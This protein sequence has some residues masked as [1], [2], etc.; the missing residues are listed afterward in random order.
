MKKKVLAI[1]I[2]LTLILNSSVIVFAAPFDLTYSAD[3]TKNYTF[4]QF[5]DSPSV[6]DFVASNLA[7]YE[8]EGL[9]GIKYSAQEINNRTMLGMDFVQAVASIKAA[10]AVTTAEGSLSQ[11]DVDIAQALI[12]GLPDGADKTALQDRLNIVIASMPVVPP[13]PLVT[14]NDV[15]NTVT[16]M[17][18]GMEYNLDNA[19]Y[20][21]YV[22]GIFNALDF[23]GNHTLLV[24]VAAVG[25]NPPS[26]DTTLTFTTNPGPPVTNDDVA[27][28]VF[29]MTTEMEY[30]YDGAAYVL[31]DEFGFNF[32]S[33]NFHGEHILLV[34]Y[35]ANP[36]GPVT[37]LI[38]TLRPGPAVINDDATNTVTGMSTAMEYNLDGAGYVTY[39][40]TTFNALDFN[41]NHILLVRYKA[42]PFLGHPASLATTLTFTTN[43][44]PQVTNDDI[45]NTVTGMTTAMEYNLDNMGYVLYDALI[46]DQIDFS[47]NH[48]LL[49]RVAAEGGNPAGPVAT[50]IF[51]TNPGVPEAPL[52]FRDD[53]ANTVTGM[54]VGMEYNYDGTGYV[55]YDEFGFVFAGLNFIGDHTLDVRYAAVGQ[56]PASLVTTLTF[57][58]N[59]VRP[60]PPVTNNDTDNTVSGMDSTMEYSYDGAAYVMYDNFFGPDVVFGALDFTG[61]HTL[62]VRYAADFMNGWPPSLDTTLTFTTNPVTLS[63]IAITTPATKLIYTVGD[64]LDIAGMVVTGTYSDSSTQ[65]ETITSANV[66]GFDS[67]AAVPSQI[68]TVTVNG[69]TTTYTVEIKAV[70]NPLADI[71]NALDAVAMSQAITT[72]A[73]AI[74]LN[75]TD[76]NALPDPNKVVVQ[77]ALI[78]P[79]FTTLAQI[80]TAFDNAV[81]GQKALVA[82]N[83]ASSANM[84]SVIT[85]Y[86]STLGLV[87]TTV[88]DYNLLTS[89]SKTIVH[90]ALIGKAFVNKTEVNTAFE[91]SVSVL[92]INELTATTP[93][94]VGDTKMESAL[95]RYRT[96]LALDAIPYDT[97]I[98]PST[99]TL[100]F[101]N[102]VNNILRAAVMNTPAE[103]RATFAA[104]VTAE[105][106]RVI[107]IQLLNFM[108]RDL[109]TY[110]VILGLN[111]TDYDALVNKV[112]VQTA[113]VAEPFTT[114]AHVKEFFDALVAQQKALEALS[115][116]DAF[117]TA[118]DAATMGNVITIYATLFNSLDY[119]YYSNTIGASARTAVQTAMLTPTFQTN[120]DVQLSF[121]IALMNNATSIYPGQIFGRNLV[122]F[123]LSSSNTE[124]E[125]LASTERSAIT[126]AVTAARPIADK[127]KIVVTALN[128]TTIESYMGT[129]IQFNNALLGLNM[130]D[131]NALINKAP[132]HLAMINALLTNAV[133]VKTV[134]D[135]AVLAQKIVENPVLV[136][137]AIT[138]PATKTTYGVGQTLSITGLVVTGTYDDNS[139][140]TVPI[141]VGNISG[142]NSTVPVLGQTLTI[143]VDGKTTTFDIDILQVVLNKSTTS[144]LLGMTDTLIATVLPFEAIN[145]DVI[146]SVQSG[147][148]SATVNNGLLTGVNL[149]IATITATTMDG[150][151]K[152]SCFVT[153]TNES[154]ILTNFN[155]GRSMTY[156]PG[157]I[158]QFGD[159]IG[160]NLTEYNNLSTDQKSL[161]QNAMIYAPTFTTLADIKATFESAMAS[162]IFDV[163]NY[164]TID[165]IGSALEI[166]ETAMSLNLVAYNSLSVSE[167]TIVHGRLLLP[168]YFGMLYTSSAEVQAVLDLAV[169]SASESVIALAEI[170]NALTGESLGTALVNNA[171]MLGMSLESYNLYGDQ[172]SVNNSIMTQISISPFTNSYDLQS[173]IDITLINQ[174]SPFNLA[175]MTTIASI[176]NDNAV[177]LG[178]DLTIYDLLSPAEQ[179]FVHGYLVLDIYLQGGYYS[180]ATLHGDFNT[181]VANATAAQIAFAEINAA[182]VD[183]IDEALINNAVLLGIDVSGYD[184]VTMNAILEP[185]VF[186][187]TYDLQF[188]I[189]GW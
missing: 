132:V 50:L 47:G 46:F 58:T 20:V 189:Y 136:S 14:R 152:A 153:V 80:K 40:A 55:M 41:G 167:Q 178:L 138:T 115:M 142:F 128:T 31:Y 82:V 2:T 172:L 67:A 125:L 24:R 169:S 17:A 161:V 12:T 135:A 114:A 127:T 124:F 173:M 107:D 151:V 102:R 98:A 184:P 118:P 48:T 106:V 141:T 91:T 28:S 9:D 70:A 86:A 32:A 1:F 134:F 92:I 62:L 73:V 185:Q 100:S 69:K 78:A 103:V 8:I 16:G 149:G 121:A 116:L 119:S 137:I 84:G 144:V 120:E 157:F 112:F 88:A 10:A 71:N 156:M 3:N 66:T 108:D 113:M 101:K 15:A 61:N 60:G 36:T 51:T 177:S 148:N 26:L 181:A 19:G 89:A 117:N 140:A 27:D 21:A 85:T 25:I 122:L 63:S 109:R 130:E 180:L 64:I 6:F 74:G 94:A 143:T 81:L 5:I 165:T 83:T 34:R 95:T 163:I 123:G 145:K 187:N 7:G 29:G 168:I 170:N 110:A 150:I 171:A 164:A 30:S 18:S 54:A 133:D 131:Y 68:L 99:N 72:H 39:A 76:Y 57:T 147:S 176:I 13:A 65:I 4:N 23:S 38:F 22:A 166:S 77:T 186:T 129:L 37:T 146:W 97:Y 87:T 160:L 93:V 104:A 175:D 155:L 126:N 45:S 56:T 159:A 79:I 42:D 11:A 182:T 154:N 90:T 33:L 35:A 75:L 96:I 43:P 53:N 111:L 139:T 59:P 179:E 44:G 158:I 183:T 162:I 105:A 188:A 52:V 174:I 49:V